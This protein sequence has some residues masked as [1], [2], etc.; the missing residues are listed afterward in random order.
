MNSSIEQ[1]GKKY[2]W[3]LIIHSRGYDAYLVDVQ[4]LIGDVAPIYRWPGGDGVADQMELKCRAENFH[5]LAAQLRDDPCAFR[6]HSD[7]FK[8]YP[9]WYKELALYAM[10]CVSQKYGP[11][12]FAKRLDDKAGWM[13]HHITKA[14]FEEQDKFDPYSDPGFIQEAARLLPW[15]IK[16]YTEG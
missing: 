8:A 10:E 7:D 4:P 12:H 9:F 3:P 16:R 2:G 6:D 1:I 14:V 13:A 5:R 11:D 15:Y